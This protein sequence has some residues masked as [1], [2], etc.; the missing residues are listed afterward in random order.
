[1]LVI[2]NKTYREHAILSDTNTY[3]TKTIGAVGGNEVTKN[4]SSK[5][6]LFKKSRVCSDRKNRDFAGKLNDPEIVLDDPVFL[7]LLSFGLTSCLAYRHRSHRIYVCNL[8]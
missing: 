1:M 7:L 3:V 6:S 4:N 8:M 2:Q 5:H